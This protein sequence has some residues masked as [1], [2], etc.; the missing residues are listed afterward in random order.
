MR[1]CVSVREMVGGDAEEE[2]SDRKK[3]IR[4]WNGINKSR[5]KEKG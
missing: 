3:G 4:R 2:D 1:E 5:V